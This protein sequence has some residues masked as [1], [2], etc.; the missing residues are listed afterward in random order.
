MHHSNFGRGGFK[1]ETFFLSGR[2]G[3]GQGPETRPGLDAFEVIQRLIQEGQKIG[4][5]QKKGKR[6][7]H[8][9][10]AMDQRHLP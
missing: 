5:R 6:A 3:Q 4:Q 8:T 7:L 10:A 1:P 9:T 2:L